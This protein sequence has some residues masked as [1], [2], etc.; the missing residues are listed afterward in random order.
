MKKIKIEWQKG[1]N[2]NS[3]RLPVLLSEKGY[4]YAHNSKNKVLIWNSFE[5]GTP[6]LIKNTTNRKQQKVGRITRYKQIFLGEGKSYK[7]YLDEKYK[8]NIKGYLQEL[9]P[10]IEA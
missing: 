1:N 5:G 6:V 4:Y 8:D 3:K 9:L 10:N 2:W 7:E